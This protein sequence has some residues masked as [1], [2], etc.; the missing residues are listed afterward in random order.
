MPTLTIYLDEKMFRCLLS[1]SEGERA[2]K[3]ARRLLEERLKEFCRPEEE[4]VSGEDK[5]KV[6]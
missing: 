3:V 1:I 2:S 5:G 6:A 4:G